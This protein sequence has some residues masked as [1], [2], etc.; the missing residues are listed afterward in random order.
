MQV[1]CQAEWRRVQRDFHSQVEERIGAPLDGRSRGMAH[2]VSDFLFTYYSF[3][4]GLLRRWSPGGGWIL[5]RAEAADGFP[6]PWRS[7]PPSAKPGRALDTAAFPRHRVD[8]LRWTLELLRA[9]D[10]RPP[11][12]AC[13]GLHE[14]AMVYR[15]RRR[16]HAEVPLRVS[17]DIVAEVVEAG[18]LGC[19]HFDAFRFFTPEARPRNR[20]TLTPD[21]RIAQEQPGCLHVTMDLYK[22]A[23]KFYPWVPSTLILAAFDLA[24]EARTLDMCASPYDW[25]DIGLDAVPVETEAGRSDYRQAQRRL[26]ESARPIRRRVIDGYRPFMTIIKSSMSL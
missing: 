8:A 14:W 7:A 19:S 4:P 2:P 25:S 21:E 6:A 15:A 12:F 10:E 5:E 24:W 9:V 1:L 20:Q 18:T 13:H 3:R 26:T 17:P 23:Y 22:W 11:Q 16:R